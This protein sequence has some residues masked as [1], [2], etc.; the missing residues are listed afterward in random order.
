MNMF[1]GNGFLFQ[2]PSTRNV[3]TN[4]GGARDWPEGMLI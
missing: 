2:K 3:L 4:A 1:L